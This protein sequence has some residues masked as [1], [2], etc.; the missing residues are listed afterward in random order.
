VGVVDTWGS[1]V[2]E[3]AA[4]YP[5]DGLAPSPDAVLFRAIDVRAPAPVVIMRKQLRTLKV[6][7]ERSASE[8]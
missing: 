8:I 2:E 4:A 5:C 7:A 1:T 3:R 6:L